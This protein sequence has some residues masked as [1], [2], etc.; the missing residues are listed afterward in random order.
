MVWT[1]CR[2]WISGAYVEFLIRSHYGHRHV[3]IM[4]SHLSVRLLATSFIIELR[5]LLSLL[6]LFKSSWE[7]LLFL[8]LMMFNHWLDALGCHDSTYLEYI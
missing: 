6:D 2:M 1:G 4:L 7:G 3:A 5:L 8:G